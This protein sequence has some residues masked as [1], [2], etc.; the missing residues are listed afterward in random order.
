[1]RGCSAAA[2]DKA[3]GQSMNRAYP[4]SGPI[5]ICQVLIAGN[6]FPEVANQLSYE[7][8]HVNLRVLAAV[9]PKLDSSSKKVAFA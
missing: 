9:Q 6:L 5:F 3:P 1:M 7:A 4:Q 2:L 8:A